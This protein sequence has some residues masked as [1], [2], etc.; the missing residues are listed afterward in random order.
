MS[1]NSCED[2]NKNNGCTSIMEPFCNGQNHH[3]PSTKM[4][5]TD[6]IRAIFIFGILVGFIGYQVK[7]YFIGA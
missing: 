6:W 1:C 3:V 4:T 5:I 7:S 2:W